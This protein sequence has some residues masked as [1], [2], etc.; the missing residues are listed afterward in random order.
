M[1]ATDIIALATAG[2]T[3][4]QIAVIAK[5][6]K[7]QPVQQPVQQPDGYADLMGRLDALTTQ[8][9]QSAILHSAQPPE[10][11]A[12]DILA[13]IIDPPEFHPTNNK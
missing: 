6:A 12:D 10:D 13:N 4:E 2:Y 9:Q 7:E 5:A 1:K 8:I 3:A 11:T